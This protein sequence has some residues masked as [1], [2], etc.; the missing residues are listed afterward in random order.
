M[1]N[2]NI[3]ISGVGIHHNGRPD[4]A[5]AMFV[6]TVDE[7]KAAGHTITHAEITAGG[8]QNVDDARKLHEGIAKDKAGS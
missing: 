6:K 8:A 4:D 1:G 7:L 5:D 3:S 2:W